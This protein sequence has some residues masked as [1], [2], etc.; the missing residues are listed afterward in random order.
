MPA[1]TIKG[2]PEDLLEKLRA[3]AEKERRSM[4][5]QA[6]YLLEEALKERRPSFFDVHAAFVEK[7]GPPPFRDDFFEGLRSH[8]VGRP[9]PFGE[10]EEEERG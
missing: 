2:I 10:E 9:S 3:L 6:I 1:I 4:N 5:Q 8:E 7:Y